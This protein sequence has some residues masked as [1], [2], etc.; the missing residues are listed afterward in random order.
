V[1]F[2]PRLPPALDRIAFR[3]CLRD[4][5]FRVVI[6]RDSATYRI[7]SGGPLHTSHHGEPIVVS[8]GG[9]VTMPIPPPP[10]RD[11]VPRQ[12]PGREPR[13]HSRFAT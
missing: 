8:V 3:M 6:E 9:H 7:V 2:A 1:T 4:T 5:R 11:E 10:R 12:P 13:H